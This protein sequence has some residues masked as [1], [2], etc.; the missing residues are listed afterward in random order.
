MRCAWH[1]NQVPRLQGC[2]R[3]TLLCVNAQH[4]AAAA[5]AT[6]PFLAEGGYVVSAQNGLNE[7]VIADIVGRERTIGASDYASWITGITGQVSS[8]SG[9]S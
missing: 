4:P 7:R 3:R 5:A 9:G 8:V 6:R 1:G 2:Y